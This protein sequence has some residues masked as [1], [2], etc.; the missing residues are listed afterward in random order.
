VWGMYALE[1]AMDEL[2]VKL[3]IDPLALRLKN[4]AERDQNEDRPFSSKEL[5]A[6]YQQGAER[7]GWAR[8]DPRPRSMRE[9][10]TLIG[11]GM[12]GGVGEASQLTAAA[13][14]V[15]TADGKLTVSSATE[16]IGTGTY[17]IMTQ[18]AAELLGLPI[19]NVTFKL[20]DSSLPQAPVE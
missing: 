14:A 16:D 13:R 5:R 1:C 2:A 17:T 8:R 4:Y 10:D 7:F 19:E 15:L 6:C 9:G 11:W 18:I 3:G 20:G 12:A